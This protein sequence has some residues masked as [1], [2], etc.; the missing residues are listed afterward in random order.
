MDASSLRKGSYAWKSIVKAR[1]FILRGACWRVGDDKT[2][3]FWKHRWLSENHH[4]KVLSPIP[5]NLHNSSVSELL[6]PSPLA[7]NTAL[8]DQLFQSYD[9]KAITSILVSERC[10]L[11]KLVWLGSVMGQYT[12]KGGYQFLLE[13]ELL[14]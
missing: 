9:A 8:I 12:I 5:K 2:I 10:P 3:K 11:D 13:E 4:R 1:D 14:N 6:L 7:W